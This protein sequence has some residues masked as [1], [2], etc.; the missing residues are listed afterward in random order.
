GCRARARAPQSWR[1]RVHLEGSSAMTAST[2]PTSTLSDRS[3]L[4][5]GAGSGLGA[6]ISRRLVRAG[7]RVVLLDIDRDKAEAVARAVDPESRSTL[8]LAADVG[9]PGKASE[10]VTAA[11]RRFGGLDALVNNAGTDVTQSLDEV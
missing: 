2:Q 1:T 7:A 9:D 5:T 6:A 8:A 4:V 10:A 11:A 3:V